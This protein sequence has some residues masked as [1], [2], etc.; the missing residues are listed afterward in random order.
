VVNEMGVDYG[1]DLINSAAIWYYFYSQRMLEKEDRQQLKKLVNK[2]AK[3]TLFSFI[4]AGLVNRGLTHLKIGKREFI[5]MKFIFRLPVRAFI[6][7]AFFN[8]GALLPTLAEVDNVYNKL[9]D[10]YIPRYQSLKK[11]CDPL[12]MNPRMLSEDDM[13]EEDREYMFVIYQKLKD[14]LIMEK[15]MKE[16]N[17]I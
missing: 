4:G 14:Q 12:V 7:F 13:S 9:Y 10:K 15:Q 2:A 16:N 6:L 3:Y 8:F 5:N 11:L 1:N 17:K